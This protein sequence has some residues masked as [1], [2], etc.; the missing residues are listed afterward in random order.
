[1]LRQKLSISKFPSGFSVE[2]AH[3]LQMRLSKLIIREDCL[4]RKLKYVAGVDVTYIDQIAIA[5]AVVLNWS[6]LKLMETK[7]GLTGCRFPYIPTLLSFREA[8]AIF[9]ALQALTLKPDIFLIEGHGLAHPYRCGLA[10]HVG[11][12]AKI[13]TIGVAKSLLCGEV[14]DSEHENWRPVIDKNEIVGAAVIT[15]ASTKPV[16]VSIGNMVTLKRAIDIVIHCIRSSRI[17]E[18]IYL[19]HK[20]VSKEKAR[21]QEEF[22]C[23]SQCSGLHCIV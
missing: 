2:K 3:Q 13:P 19:A 15:K 10:S 9:K 1:M 16:Y 7:I 17:P 22:K 8:P 12:T 4:P 23:Q 20:I 21:L 18:P 6:S 14:Y 5:A 11:V